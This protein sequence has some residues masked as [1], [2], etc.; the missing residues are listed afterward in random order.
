MGLVEDRNEDRNSE[1]Q[2]VFADEMSNRARKVPRRA[3]SGELA[4]LKP[5]P[6]SLFQ[7][8]YAQTDV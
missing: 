5:M 2:D 8:S 4:R 3:D 6:E 7:L 1:I